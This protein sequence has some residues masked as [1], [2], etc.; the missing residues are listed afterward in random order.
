MRGGKNQGVVVQRSPVKG[1]G[2]AEQDE[3]RPLECGREM[4]RRRVATYART[5]LR[6]ERGELGQRECARGVREGLLRR[7]CDHGNVRA[8]RGRSSTGD[9]AL[10]TVHILN[11][12]D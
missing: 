11:M 6:H 12:I 5:R 10:E 8:L 9:A 1:I 3:L 2:G 7:S 4:H